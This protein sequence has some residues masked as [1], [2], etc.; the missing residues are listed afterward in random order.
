[1]LLYKKHRHGQYLL[2]TSSCTAIPIAGWLLTTNIHQNFVT[3]RGNIQIKHS[4]FLQKHLAFRMCHWSSHSGHRLL[5]LHEVPLRCRW[6]C[7]QLT[8]RV[9]VGTVVLW[10]TTKDPGYPCSGPK[11]CRGCHDS[12]QTGR[13]APHLRGRVVAFST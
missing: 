6:I 7:W 3:F 2:I 10:L 13:I 8:S 9:V 1:M 12:S 4:L 11:C 5:D